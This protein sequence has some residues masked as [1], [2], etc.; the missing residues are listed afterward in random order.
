MRQIEM[1]DLRTQYQEIQPEMDCAIRSVITSGQ[2]VRGPQVSELEQALCAY[3]GAKHCIAV[4]N[5]TDAL[6]IALMALGLKAG[7]E[8]IVPDFTFI[9]TAEA[10]ALLG[11]KPVAVDVDARTMLIDVHR[12]EEVITE[13]TKAI[14]PVH[15]YGQMADMSAIRTIADRYHLKIVEDGAQAIGATEQIDGVTR[16]A[17]TIGDIGCTSFFPSKNLGCYGDGGA[18]FTNDDSL[19]DEIRAIANHGSKVRYHNYRIGLNSRLDTLQAAILLAKLP[20]LASYTTARQQAAKAYD[21]ALVSIP[22]I[23]IPARVPNATHVF[24]QYTIC[25]PAHKR[26]TLRQFLQQKG[27]PTMIYYPIPVHKQQAYATMPM[28]TS[29]PVSEHLCQT[30]LSLPMH[31]CLDNEQIKYITDSIHEFFA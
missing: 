19:A 13:R 18:L 22:E 20:H 21:E 15:L 9:A 6:T 10:A 23:T 4:G 24:H 30:V 31:T 26:D 27:I 5:G 3:T 11:L 17:M 25:V 14:I 16:Q 28:S 8:V 29:Y 2:F 1:V 12:I 7:D